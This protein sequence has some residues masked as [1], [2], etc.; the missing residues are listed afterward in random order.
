MLFLTVS[1]NSQ[2][3]QIVLIHGFGSSLKSISSV[4]TLLASSAVL[5]SGSR[6]HYEQH[7]P[8]GASTNDSKQHA[9][10]RAHHCPPAPH[11]F[12]RSYLHSD[13]A[14]T[15]W[16]RSPR[17]AIARRTY[18]T[19]RELVCRA[20]T[21]CCQKYQPRWHRHIDPNARAVNCDSPPQAP[22]TVCT[23]CN[24]VSPARQ[25]CKAW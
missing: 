1:Q 17:T 12:D 9:A 20:L 22:L 23:T 11:N 25:I 18:L 19:A 14:S 2:C 7:S 21:P 24:S 8:S 6:T 10:E 16:N 13:A 15:R 3:T 5:S 4:P